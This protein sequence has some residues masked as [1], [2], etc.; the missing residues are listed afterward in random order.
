MAWWESS[1]VPLHLGYLTRWGEEGTVL[2][3]LRGRGIPVVD[4]SFGDRRLA[5]MRDLAAGGGAECWTEVRATLSAARGPEDLTF[6]VEGVVGV[7]GVQRWTDDVLAAHPDDPLALLVSGAGHVGWAWKARGGA[8]A[9]AVP[10]PQRKLFGERLAIAEERLLDVAER[11]PDWAAPRYF[12][13]ICGRGL[14]VGPEAAESRFEAT[15]RRAP[16]HVAAHAQHLQQ[17]S[18]KWGGSHEQMFA[19]AR[20]AVDAAPEG[21]GLGQLVAMAH[22]ETWLDAGGDETSLFLHDPEVVRELHAAAARSV[23]H[24]AFVKERDWAVG[25][26]TFAMAF[27]LA[28]QDAAAR[29]MFGSVGSRVTEKPWAY[30]DGRS[31]V[32]PFLAWRRRVGA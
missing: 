18:R 24:P 22:L 19:F 2:N 5:R 17:L 31:P 13:Q 7:S 28:G 25:V 30:L 8:R 11:E 15:C 6:L 29:V 32:V 4:R 21:S 1:G 23:H 3:K 27:A 20:T 14:Q 12:L 16:G 10:E 9:N 26:N